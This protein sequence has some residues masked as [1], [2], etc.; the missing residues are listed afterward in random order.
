MNVECR[1][2]GPVNLQNRLIDVDSRR[3]QVGCKAGEDIPERWLQAGRKAA[4]GYWVRGWI[5]GNKSGI[6]GAV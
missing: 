6:T 1:Q 3:D 4:I 5:F 2:T